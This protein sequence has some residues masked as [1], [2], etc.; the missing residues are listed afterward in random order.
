L[1]EVLIPLGYQLG[2]GGIGGFVVG[3]ALKKLAKLVVFIIGIF[4][5][6][7]LYMGYLGVINVN[8]EGLMNWVSGALGIVGGA[9][10]WLSAVVSNLT[11]AASFTVGFYLG[12]RMG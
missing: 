10:N 6:A 5:L 9:G 8:Y 12:L 3:F 4:V 7:L 1:S 11:F 2:V